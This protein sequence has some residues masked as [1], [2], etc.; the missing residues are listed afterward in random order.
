[1][2][3]LEEKGIEIVEAMALAGKRDS[4]IKGIKEINAAISQ[5]N[6]SLAELKESVDA[7]NISAA[8]DIATATKEL[9][10]VTNELNRRLADLK[11]EGY[12]LPIGGGKSGKTT[13]L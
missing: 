12:T 9:D 5:N 13:A 1:M 11:K 7:A 2:S 10:G 6:S 4:I 8:S 3:N